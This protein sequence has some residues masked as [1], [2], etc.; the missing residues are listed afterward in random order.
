MITKAPENKAMAVDPM[1][2]E[3]EQS[4]PEGVDEQRSQICAV[5]GHLFTETIQLMVNSPELYA[6]RI[7][8]K[9]LCKRCGSEIILAEIL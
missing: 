6:D 8:E 3:G 7:P 5:Q 2:T 4:M 9:S 1:Y